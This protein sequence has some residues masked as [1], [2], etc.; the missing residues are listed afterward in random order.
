MCF[1]S[2]FNYGNGG[3]E[4]EN[5]KRWNIFISLFFPT[6]FFSGLH[7]MSIFST[8]DSKDSRSLLGFSHFHFI[9]FSRLSAALMIFYFMIF[10]PGR[11]NFFT[12][13]C[14]CEWTLDCVWDKRKSDRSETKNDG[15]MISLL[16]RDA[17]HWVDTSHGDT[18]QWRA[19]DEWKREEM[20]KMKQA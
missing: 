5:H 12:H 4:E 11:I 16:P 2:A 13:Y 20:N 17:L 7:L 19:S 10:H 9:S 15:K 18:S 3:D 1:L 6:I 8:M 14:G